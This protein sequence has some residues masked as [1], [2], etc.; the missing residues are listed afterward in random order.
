MFFA[1][2]WR[3]SMDMI[4]TIQFSGDKTMPFTLVFAVMLMKKG[5]KAAL[6]VSGITFIVLAAAF[7]ATIM[8]IVNAMNGRPG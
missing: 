5:W 7:V 1:S 2:L 6:I 8:A 3:L 4:V